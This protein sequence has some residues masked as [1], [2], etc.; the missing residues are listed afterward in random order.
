MSSRSARVFIKRRLCGRPKRLSY[1]PRTEMQRFEAFADG[2]IVSH[3]I[4]ETKPG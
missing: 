2:L 1:H 4:T 3:A